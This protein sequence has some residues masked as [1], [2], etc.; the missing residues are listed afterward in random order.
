MEGLKSEF[1]VVAEEVS[2]VCKGLRYVKER[3]GIV[4][5]EVRSLKDIFAYAD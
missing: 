1:R 2:E 3:L 5:A 4:E